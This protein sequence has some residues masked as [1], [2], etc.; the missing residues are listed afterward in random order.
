MKTKSVVF[1][2]A[3]GVV[4]LL[5]VGLGSSWGRI[6]P[7]LAEVPAQV[8]SQT[9][10]EDMIPLEAT[11][12]EPAV[13]NST[14]KEGVGTPPLDSTVP[15]GADPF[16]EAHEAL[17]ERPDAYWTIPMS[18]T[19]EG[20]FPNGLWSPFDNNGATGG[21]VYWDD[22]SF[23]P[24]VGS[25]SAWA[26]NGG[27]NGVNPAVSNYPN[28]M[29]SWLMYGPFD[30]SNCAAA[31]F[32]FYYWNK[33]EP[34][35]DFF[36]WGGSPNGSNLY[37]WQLSGDQATW[38]Y[39]DF[40]LSPYLGDSSVWLGFIFRSD[41]I[42]TDIG[43]FVDDVT[44]W[45]L[46][47][48]TPVSWTY[49]VYLD[50]DNNLEAAA[51]DDFLE[52]SSV[53]SSANVDIV[54][55]FDRISGYS[56]AYDDWT[57]TRRFH[58]TA[59]MTPTIANSLV[60]VGEANMGDPE[61]LLN[62]IR[63]GR[64]AYPATNYAVVLWDHGSG[65]TL[66]DPDE[67]L[68][69]GIAYDD[70]SADNINMP[71]MRSVLSTFTS[72]GANPI[73]L[74]GLD[75]CLMAMIEVDNQ[76]KPYADVRVTS[77][78][79]EPADGWPHNTI[80]AGLVANPGWTASQLATRI[81]DDYYTSYGN[82]QTQSAV[83]LGSLYTSLNTATNTFANTL[84]AWAPY[85]RTEI[86]NARN[87]AQTFSN[88]TYIDLWDFSDWVSIYASSS[89]ELYNAATAV[90]NA[91]LAS[92]IRE[93]SGASWPYAQGI[94]IY[95]PKTAGE[96]DARYDGGSGFLQFT[97]STQWDEWVHV[98][99]NLAN[100][101][102]NFNKSSPA[103]GV[104]DQLLGLTL[105]WGAST[106]ATSYS[107]CFDTSN[108][109]A[110]SNWSTL[111]NLTSVYLGGLSPST[112]Y[113]W[114]VR[115]TNL[116][117]TLYANM[118]PTAYWSFTTG[119]LPGA[120]G[121]SSPANGATNV[122][123]TPTLSWG[124]STNVSAYYYCY[125]TTNDNACSSWTSNGTATSVTLPALTTGTTY[126]W[127]VRATNAI[128][129]T[130]S[131]GSATA[132]WSFATGTPP[133][134]FGK[135]SPPNGATN[136]PVSLTLSWGAAT[137]A[138]YYEA[139]I[140]STNDHSCSTWAN[141]GNV[142][143]VAAGG[144]SFGTTYYWHVRAV[145]SFGVTYS[146]G[147]S[148][149]D[150]ALTTGSPPGVFSKTS[151]AN[152][153][154]NQPL[155]LTLSWGT[156]SGAASYEYCYDTTN[157]NA[158]SSWVNVGSATSA[159]IGPLSSGTTFYWHV[160][161]LNSFGT[162]YSNG[163]NTAFWSFTTGFPPGAFGKTSP[164]NGATTQPLNPTLSWGASSGVTFYEYC[165]DTTNDGACTTWVNNGTATSV[166]IGTLSTGTTY[167]WQVRATNSFGTTYA[168]GSSTAYWS[169]TTGFPPGAF[170]KS[171]PGN[172]ASG[173]SLNPT[174]S[175]AASSGVTFYEYCFDTTNDG[176]CTTWVN[177]GT[178]TSVIIG[179]LSTNTTYYWQVRATNS[180]GTTYA[181]G[182]STA[183]WSFTTGS[184]PAAFSKISPSNLASG[185]STSPTL[186]WGTASG[187]AGYEYCYDTTNDSACSV[188]VSTGASTSAALSGL[189][190]G[191][192]Y[193]WQVRALNSFGTTYAEGS[194]TAF[195]SFTTGNLPGAF[196]KIS[197][198]NTATD[199]PT[200]L[201]LTWGA[202]S[203]AS[204]YEYCYD[205]SNDNACSGWVSTGT[206]T[207]ASLSGLSYGA[208]YYWQVRALNGFGTTY[209]EGSSTAYWSFTIGLPPAN[210]NKISPSSG[211][212]DQP[213]SLVLNW[214]SSV[215]ASSYEYC[216]D[217]IDNHECDGVWISTGMNTN[218]VISGL[219]DDATYF[220]QVRA[221]NAF[222]SMYA[223]S[224]TWWSFTTV[225]VLTYY[226]YMPLIMK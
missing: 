154:T 85:Y 3:L 160:R 62:F 149:D 162:T 77:Q 148:A 41:Y 61:T 170:V 102:A 55:Q 192:T 141:L 226:I 223:D 1:S 199:Q 82:N 30:L 24:H 217:T 78:E 197:P 25:W 191:A 159:A 84:I 8:S 63:W 137:G 4:L 109:N 34:G 35:Y 213:L 138:T 156:A 91:T 88:L 164:S 32:E 167:Y 210:F 113:Y 224:E 153:A 45:C 193:Y 201:T 83:N 120:F 10:E 89:S 19:F 175:W 194:S 21:E 179:T 98:Y 198:G 39:V 152:A 95:F 80:L 144:F 20:T 23:K 139:C 87:A 143:S 171:V 119:P 150:W 122:S 101:P 126:Y 51:V 225:D 220:W 168:E 208:T 130:Y 202:S 212:L 166:V 172:G 219:F 178:S 52:M 7:V 14:P 99:H 129:T 65:W 142:T 11:L 70:T 16:K 26:A 17:P 103:N 22:D 31:D 90:E 57:D 214:G 110:C 124:T 38:N 54:V 56:T 211:A 46:I 81:V 5:T 169:F 60:S 165:F 116:T 134:A 146:N 33:S 6:R 207:S 100:Y 79:T 174:L 128:G 94:S 43:A 15:A 115:A 203:G 123:L 49:M 68:T 86:T 187:A 13:Y 97:G 47:E 96:F 58:I 145:N 173:V 132:F 67:I 221:L 204:S 222:G 155:S 92:V 161:A 105:S 188:W 190:Y 177:N 136:Q 106:G 37:G 176:A 71:E 200:S 66:R 73:E 18:E 185:I 195:W 112:T 140:D 196:G 40:D 72:A 12:G 151:P 184:P 28:D 2:R 205:N 118:A 133:G 117:G 127:H 186:S 216:Y 53:G 104:T 163:S 121:K 36:G 27:V 131:N 180:F 108:D 135:S 215:G 209:A 111:G 74:F 206:T 69:K 75:A 218:A 107:L 44:L 158:C 189:T 114:Q 64:A 76:I 29:D 182:S 147:T 42:V 48:D 181:E 50:G 9:W 59:G 93:Q 125:D 183:F 157:D